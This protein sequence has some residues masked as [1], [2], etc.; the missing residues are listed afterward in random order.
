METGDNIDITSC[1]K[2]NAK[3]KGLL[4][5]I[6]TCTNSESSCITNYCINLKTGV[7]QDMTVCL[8]NNSRATCMKKYGC[9]DKGNTCTGNCKWTYKKDSNVIYGVETCGTGN[10]CNFR[11]DCL[12]GLTSSSALECVQNK[13]GTFDI[14]SWFNTSYNATKLKNSYFLVS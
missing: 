6:D 13:L 14:M 10:Y 1:V 3:S 4:T 7:S 11:V 9:V 2:T 12:T 5:A 8:K